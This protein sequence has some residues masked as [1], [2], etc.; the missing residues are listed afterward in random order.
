MK[1]RLS[2]AEVKVDCED[3]E[4]SLQGVEEDL[5]M[6]IDFCLKTNNWKHRLSKIRMKK[7]KLR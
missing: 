2:G 1:T 7:F 6:R 4:A 5:E 3:K